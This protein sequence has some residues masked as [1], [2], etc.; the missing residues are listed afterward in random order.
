M[1][2]MNS[3]HNNWNISPNVLTSAY[4][5]VMVALDVGRQGKCPLERKSRKLK[6]TVYQSKLP[7]RNK[8]I[9]INVDA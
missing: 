9:L 5:H 8:D 6:D 4:W 3:V 1:K 7:D 2:K